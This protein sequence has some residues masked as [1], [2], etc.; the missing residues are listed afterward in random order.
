MESWK[1]SARMPFAT[2]GIPAQR[3]RLVDDLVRHALPTDTAY[4]AA[5]VLAELVTN[6]VQHGGPL[7]GDHLDLCWGAWEGRIHIEVTDAGSTT[8]PVAGSASAVEQRGRGLAIVAALAASW[9]V[10]AEDETVTVW[11]ELP[12][13]RAAA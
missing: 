4:D 2:V 13:D 12:A 11:A 3:H 10:R 1:S 5:L 7:A 6:A 8:V 9:G